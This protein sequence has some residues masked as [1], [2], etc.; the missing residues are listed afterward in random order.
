MTKDYEHNQADI[1]RMIRYIKTVDPDNATPEMAIY[2]LESQYAKDHL[3]GHDDPELTYT[4]YK[5]YRDKKKPMT[6][7]ER[8]R[9][10]KLR[11][12]KLTQAFVEALSPKKNPK[13]S[14]WAKN[15]KKKLN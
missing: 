13:P 10:N 3:L 6:P 9:V 14:F 11:S 5:D 2:L 1:D 7:Q 4:I 15:K 8:A 12:D